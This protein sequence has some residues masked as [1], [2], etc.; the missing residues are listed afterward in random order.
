MSVIQDSRE[1][2]K[3]V[4]NLANAELLE[5]VTKLNGEVVDLSGQT[6]ELQQQVFDLRRKLAEAEEKLRLTGEV[7]RE[8]N[9]YYFRKGESVGLCPRC[10]ESDRKLISV[11]HMLNEGRQRFAC[12]ACKSAY[13]A[14]PDR[15]IPPS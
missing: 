1:V 7:E 2:V 3:L 5:K 4:A 8:A 14:L 11:V 15:N 12:P 10:W 6:V 9:G 13:L